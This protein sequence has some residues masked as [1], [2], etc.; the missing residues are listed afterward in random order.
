M[1]E[2]ITIRGRKVQL[3]TARG[4]EHEVE[5]RPF[6]E[7]I[8]S[9]TVQGLEEEPNPDN[10]VWNVRCGALR[11]CI[12]QLKPE[13][14]LLQWLSP[15]SPVPF[16][17]GARTSQRQLATP[18]VIIKAPFHRGRL[19]PRVEV[20]YRAAP[21]GSKDGP[22][23]A[24]CF[25]NLLN[26]SPHA[27]D[28]VSWFCTQYLPVGDLPPGMAAGLDAIIHHLWG[29]GFNASSEEHEGLS[30]FGLTVQKEIDERVANVDRWEAESQRDPRFVL[31]VPWLDARVSV[32]QLIERE[33]KFHH[34]AP[35]PESVRVLGNLLLRQAHPR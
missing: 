1:G 17:P 9:C 2:K 28:C 33:M 21:L 10:V 15:D 34:V 30:G 26:V 29:G 31:N 32:A 24:L 18:Y 6:C 13:L 8:A 3:S 20:F 22:G 35:S 14:R 7:A 5:L 12:A 16:G 19:Q 11:I 27:Y 4:E 23:G 25:P